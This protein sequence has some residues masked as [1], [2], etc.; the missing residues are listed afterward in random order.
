MLENLLVLVAFGGTLAASYFDLKTTEIPDRIPLSMFI[1]GLSVHLYTFLKTGDIWSLGYP[2]LVGGSL[3]LLGI[4]MYYTGQWGGGDAK[5]LGAVGFLLPRA[6]QGFSSSLFIN[7]PISFLMNLFLVGAVYIIFYSFIFAF[8]NQNVIKGFLRD[9]KGSTK[10]FGIFVISVTLTTF[11]IFIGVGLRWGVSLSNI[12]SNLI[13][14]VY[15]IPASIG[16]F[17]L[18]RFLRVV[19]ETGF[20]KRINVKH[21]KEGDMLGEDIKE[22]GL[23]SKIIRGLTSEEVERIRKSGKKKIWIKEGVRFGPAF[24]IALAITLLYGSLIVALF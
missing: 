7:F 4:L 13:I 24:P 12:I 1:L 22:L 16:I 21:L 18:W 11:A 20:R 23:S 8:M 10:E 3:F 19:E 5:L 9:L 14:P 6:P 2:L 15:L 17:V